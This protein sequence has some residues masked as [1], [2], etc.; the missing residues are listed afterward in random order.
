MN[1][2][3]LNILFFILTISLFAQ[4]KNFTL[5]DV[6]FNSYSSLAPERL[7]QLSWIPNTN[8]VSQVVSDS[9]RQNLVMTDAI[10]GETKNLT[11]LENI[12]SQI[13]KTTMGNQLKRFPRYSW[14]TKTSFTF[15]QD[16][17]LYSYDIKSNK[18]EMINS[19]CSNSANKSI[20][21]NNKYV[22]LTDDNNLS[23]V[24]CKI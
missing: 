24:L 9:S 4:N 10:T 18:L 7:R 15:W 14:V 22:A 20:A 17:S 21:P 8:T 16:S 19:V 12:N 3:K 5:E 13:T 11:S 1:F 23:V 6:V 2:I